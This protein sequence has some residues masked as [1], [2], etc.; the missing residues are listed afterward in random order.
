MWTMRGKE[1]SMN[2]KV[3]L[4]AG[5]G[6]GNGTAL[7]RKFSDLGYRVAMLAR[8]RERLEELEAQIPRS[9]GY[10]VDIGDADAVSAACSEIRQD[11]G[12]IDVLV[13]NAGSGSFSSF[14]DTDPAKLEQ[15]FRTNTLSL[16]LLGQQVV[17]DMLNAGGGSIVVIGATAS[18]RGGAAFA[19]FAPSKAAQRSL[20]QSMARS[21]GPQ[22]IHVAYVIID[23][24]IDIPRTRGFFKDK[25][26]EFFLRPDAIAD[27]VAQLAQQDR[28][29]WTFEL[30][31][32][33]F[34]E[35]W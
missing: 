35:K 12:P 34:S 14:M 10:A 9:K 19:G 18:I 5:V 29:A 22:G 20:A 28:S 1:E 27:T 23:G 25:P 6:P 30:D 15:G 2:E 21:L 17:P 13:H 16:L 24:V 33:P 26:D 8:T 3:C 7:S 4:V 11:L 32:R 31:L